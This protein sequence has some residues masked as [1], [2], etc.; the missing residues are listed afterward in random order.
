MSVTDLTPW[1]AAGAGLA[2]LILAL[3]IAYKIVTGTIDV[4]KLL[5][6][7][8]TGQASTS[9]FQLVVFSF[10]IAFS[11]LIVLINGLSTAGG[12]LPEIPWS[13][14]ALLGVSAA[15]YAAGKKLDESSPPTAEPP[16]DP[17]KG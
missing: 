16:K 15:T 3:T 9:R 10:V 17:A 7:G 6:D 5:S 14:L 4:T 13:L 1:L 8:T 12:K 11:Y 2:V